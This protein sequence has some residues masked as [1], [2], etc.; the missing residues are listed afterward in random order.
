MFSCSFGICF[1][2]IVASPPDENAGLTPLAPKNPMCPPSY[3]RVHAFVTLAP[4]AFFFFIFSSC[5]PTCSFSS[6]AMQ[7]LMALHVFIVQLLP[8]LPCVPPSRSL[9][10]LFSLI[11]LFITPP[12][13]SEALNLAF[14]AIDPGLS[15]L[16]FDKPRFP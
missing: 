8:K 16:A 3:L 13:D 1:H 6:S 9:I 7:W 10:C 2:S 5:S 12:S 14:D 15:I 4:N 11:V